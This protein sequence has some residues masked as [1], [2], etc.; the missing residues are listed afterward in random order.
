MSYGDVIRAFAEPEGKRYIARITP[1]A[2]V[3]A[4]LLGAKARILAVY[5]SVASERTT[6]NARSHVSPTRS[7]PKLRCGSLCTSAKPQAW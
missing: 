2:Y 6:Y 7:A 5:R 1:Y 4:E 3:A